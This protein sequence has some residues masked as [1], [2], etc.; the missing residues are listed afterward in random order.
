M[1]RPQLDDPS[2]DGKYIVSSQIDPSTN[3]DIVLL[4]SS[5][6]LKPQHIA[7][8]A[9]NET[10]GQISPDGKWLAYTSDETGRFEIFVQSFPVPGSKR[11]V[12]TEGGIQARWRRDGKELFY[13]SADNMLMSIPVSP[14]GPNTFG[15]PVA[16]FKMPPF[17]NIT[18]LGTL[19][20]YD[21]SP[22]GQRILIN[23]L[24]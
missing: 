15:V 13:V 24:Q 8:T 18:G 7:A 4:S 9:A 20:Q 1:D 21:V 17:R 3:R 2:S 19:A 22:D 5:G 10:Q 14:T 16:L 6:D 23:V 12:S 11:L